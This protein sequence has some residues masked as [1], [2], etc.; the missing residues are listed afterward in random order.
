MGFWYIYIT[1]QTN[2][3][4]KILGV[5]TD[6]LLHGLLNGITRKQTEPHKLEKADKTIEGS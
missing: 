5:K 3:N 4:G 1:N 6:L 2:W